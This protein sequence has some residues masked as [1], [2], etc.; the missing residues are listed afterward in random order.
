MIFS[1]LFLL[2]LSHD[3]FVILYC[4][5]SLLFVLPALDVS[6]VSVTCVLLP[7]FS[8]SL[9]CSCHLLSSIRLAVIV[10]KTDAKAKHAQ[11]HTSTNIITSLSSA[12]RSGK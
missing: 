4:S 2:S 5:S 6:C 11:E 10:V 9:I 3:L 8:L 7:S 1:L 12:N